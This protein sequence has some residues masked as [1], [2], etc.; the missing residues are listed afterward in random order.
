MGKILFT[1]LLVLTV[2]AFGVVGFFLFMGACFKAWGNVCVGKAP[3][4][5]S[6]D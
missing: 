3:L 1:G 5:E 6:E 2:G 4:S